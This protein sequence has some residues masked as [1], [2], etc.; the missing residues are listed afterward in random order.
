MHASTKPPRVQA[1][2]LQQQLLRHRTSRFKA[3]AAR[4]CSVC[5]CCRPSAAAAGTRTHETAASRTDRT[6]IG[7][8]VSNAAPIQHRGRGD[9]CAVVSANQPQLRTFQEPLHAV[10]GRLRSETASFK[11]H[12]HT[13][14]AHACGT[15]KE[16]GCRPSLPPMSKTL[17]CPT[18]CTWAH[19]VCYTSKAQWTYAS[20]SPSTLWQLRTYGSIIKAPFPAPSKRPNRIG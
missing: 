3:R 19:G 11:M 10:H 16:E 6:A 15:D 12:P 8:A 13:H 18:P 14:I 5:A 20:C 2:H 9:S 4:R 17:P 7:A 1:P